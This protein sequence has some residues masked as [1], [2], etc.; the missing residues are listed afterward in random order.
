MGKINGTGNTR[1]I[2]AANQDAALRMIKANPSIK[3]ADIARRLKLSPSTITKWK[4]ENIMDWAVRYQQTLREA[5]DELEGPAIET[6]GKLIK[7]GNFQASK[8]VLDNKNYGAAQ[9][10]DANVSG[11]ITIDVTIED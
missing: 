9:K 8:Y 10:I 2:T 6:M 5:F 3:F 4:S 7:D 1:E 11:D